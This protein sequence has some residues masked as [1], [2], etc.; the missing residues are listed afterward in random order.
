MILLIGD[1][2]PW[3]SSRYKHGCRLRRAYREPDRQ[4]QDLVLAEAPVQCRIQLDARPVIAQQ[5][6]LHLLL[7]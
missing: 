2:T 7:L 6:Q 1:K 5:V 3:A 4:Q